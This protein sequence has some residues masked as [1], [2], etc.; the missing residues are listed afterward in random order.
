[1]ALNLDFSIE[2]AKR[3][4]R[5]VPR[6]HFDEAIAETMAYYKHKDVSCASV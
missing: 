6:F 5:Y 2:K 1:M 4:L 3:E